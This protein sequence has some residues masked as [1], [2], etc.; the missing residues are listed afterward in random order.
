MYN[1]FRTEFVW[2]RTYYANLGLIQAGVSPDFDLSLLPLEQKEVIDFPKEGLCENV[3]LI[4]P[5]ICRPD[6]I[7]DILQN[8]GVI[9]IL[10]DALQDLQHISKWCGSSPVNN[11]IRVCSGFCGM[12]FLH[13]RAR[14]RRHC[15]D[16]PKQDRT[17]LDKKDRFP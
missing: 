15:V 6:I 11:L 9:K 5:V 16:I 12:G 14:C 7:K 8:S 2:Q 1:I 13:P 3:I 4:D 10:H 17:G